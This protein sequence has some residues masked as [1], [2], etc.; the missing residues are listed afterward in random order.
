MN[1]V[2]FFESMLTP[3]IITFVYWLA[4]LGVVV[5]GLST[6]FGGY[7]G[8]TFAKFLMGIG[9]L[10]GGGVRARIWCELLIVLVQ[11]SREHQEDCGEGLTA[12]VGPKGTG[13]RATTP[14]ARG[15]FVCTRCEPSRVVKDP[16]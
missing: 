11:N 14:S 7:G 6:M 10:V 2:F 12:S 3:K 8:I 16:P 5:S 9:I 15:S 4:L 1:K 13:T